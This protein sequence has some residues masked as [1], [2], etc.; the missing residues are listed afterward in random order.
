MDADTLQPVGSSA[1]EY[2][3]YTSDS[4]PVG[5]AK[6]V[7]VLVDLIDERER[8]K[9]RAT[10]HAGRGSSAY[11]DAG[12]LKAAEGDLQGF[13]GC[14][15]TLGRNG[16]AP[17]PWHAPDN[18][19]SLKVNPDCWVDFHEVRPNGR[20]VGGDATAFR[21]RYRGVSFIEAVRELTAMYGQTERP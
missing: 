6:L 1:S 17:C 2:R 15:V 20:Y 8:R 16:M 11:A 19:P 7:R 18:R 12:L 10:N 13:I 9:L 4:D 21:M 5:R 14:Y 3:A